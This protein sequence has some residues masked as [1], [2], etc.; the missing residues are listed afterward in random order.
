MGSFLMVHSSKAPG[1]RRVANE[2]YR[3]YGGLPAPLA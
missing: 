3:Y 1:L 2:S